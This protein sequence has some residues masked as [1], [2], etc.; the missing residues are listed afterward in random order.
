LYV[1]PTTSWNKIYINLSD[2]ILKNNFTDEFK[3]YFKAGIYDE[4]TEAVVGLDNIK[5]VFK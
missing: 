3:I 1:N 4:F 2:V 5:V